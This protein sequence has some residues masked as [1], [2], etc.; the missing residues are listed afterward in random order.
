MSATSMDPAVRTAAAAWLR[1]HQL[2]R[3]GIPDRETC[4]D[5]IGAFIAPDDFSALIA[6][7]AEQLAA[8]Q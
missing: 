5:E 2:A 1:R 7:V 8:E 3:Q 6:E 4:C